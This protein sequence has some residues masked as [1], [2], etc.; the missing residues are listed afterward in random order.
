MK[1]RFQFTESREYMSFGVSGE[2]A[3]SVMIGGD[4]GVA[5]IDEDTLEGHAVDYYLT[6]KSQCSGKRGSCPDEN[7]RVS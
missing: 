3:E 6:D 4:P 2:V 1:R 5:W 7:I